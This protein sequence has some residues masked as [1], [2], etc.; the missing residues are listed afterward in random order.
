V[1][2]ARHVLSEERLHDFNQQQLDLVIA[3]IIELVAAVQIPVLW[4][5]CRCYQERHQPASCA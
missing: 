3:A 1:P 4:S 5:M 2:G